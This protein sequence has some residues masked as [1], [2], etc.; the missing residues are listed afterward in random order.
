MH[1]REAIRDVLASYCQLC[2]DGRFAE[3]A[4]LFT[5][6]ARL[7]VMGTTHHGRAAVRSFIEA[8][9]PPERRGKHLVTNVLVALDGDRAR[10]WSDYL[11]VDRNGTPTSV[12]RYHDELR[13]EEGRWRFELRE[14]VFLG[15]TPEV[16]HPVPG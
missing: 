8:A 7:H 10:T 16:A 13:R 5:D 3:W 12:G 15:D 6:D 2:D 4:E 1:H 14:I 9:Q 11:F